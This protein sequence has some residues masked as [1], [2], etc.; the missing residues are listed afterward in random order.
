VLKRVSTNVA[1][2]GCGVALCGLTGGACEDFCG[3]RPGLC[4]LYRVTWSNESN[5][6]AILTWDAG[7]ARGILWTNRRLVHGRL[8]DLIH[9]W[10]I[11]RVWVGQEVGVL[12]WSDLAMLPPELTASVV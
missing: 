9:A 1:S 5:L 6:A 7:E 11:Y 8:S 3:D 4:G 10:A 12:H 2:G